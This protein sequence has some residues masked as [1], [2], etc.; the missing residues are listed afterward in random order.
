MSSISPIEWSII[1]FKILRSLLKYT[2][3][4]IVIGS[5]NVAAQAQNADNNDLAKDGF[6]DVEKILKSM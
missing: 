2:A 6:A 4:I 1:V 3:F 5:F